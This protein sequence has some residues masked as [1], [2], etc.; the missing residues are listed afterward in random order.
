MISKG[1]DEGQAPRHQYQRREFIVHFDFFVASY[2][3]LF[4]AACV[5]EGHMSSDLD[6]RLF[7][8]Y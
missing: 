8:W 7:K 3:V 2:A 5:V 1:A 6:T 4:L